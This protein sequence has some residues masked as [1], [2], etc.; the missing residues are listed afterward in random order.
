MKKCSP[1]HAGMVFMMC[2]ASMML[3]GF[4]SCEKEEQFSANEPVPIQLT[5]EQ[6]LLLEG[7]Q[8][9]A[10]SLLREV[11]AEAEETENVFISPL[12][13]S[14]ALAMT[15]NGAAGETRQAMHD[16]M[17]LPDIS[18]SK[19][20]ESFRKLI[21]D[22]QSV[23][24]KVV[25]TIANSIWVREGYEVQP[26]FLA[27][28]TKYF[29]AEVRELDFGRPDATNIINNWVYQKTNQLID[30]IIDQIPRETIMYLINA[31]YFNGQWKFSFDPDET[32]S[33]PFYI[34]PGKAVDVMMMRQT[35]SFP[36]YSNDLF[37]AAELPYGR[38]NY[39]MVVV[40]PHEHDGLQQI[41]D[42]AGDT[43]WREL[44]DRLSAPHELTV[45]FPRLKFAFDQKLNK[46]LINMGMGVA[47]DP[48]RADFS[49]INPNDELF[50]SRVLH[51]AFVDVNEE[52]TEAAAVTAV[53]IGRTSI[54]P[55]MPTPFI[56][57]R[58]FLFF[59]KEKYTNAVIFAA[60]VKE[61]VVE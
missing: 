17:H 53:E 33:D 26:P 61:P 50:I 7:G 34:A 40:L 36:Y 44:T 5:T 60:R 1:K 14:L 2:M 37:S 41:V 24:P 45:H 58:P 19:V 54:G 22:L 49:G 56:I 46:A 25:L 59:I 23:D 27:T 3:A 30:K 28:N 10:F 55:P 18:V 21:A 9:F 52:G 39:S 12:S 32:V 8:G 16:A 29:D 15:Y 6:K 51:K 57:N 35:E 38:G 48:G 31:I 13:V 20:N 47:F 42:Q 4:S 43:F 11:I